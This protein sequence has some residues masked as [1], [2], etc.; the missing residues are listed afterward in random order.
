MM[1]VFMLYAKPCANIQETMVTNNDNKQRIQSKG[2][3][4]HY[5]WMADRK[6]VV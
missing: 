2:V 1:L 5:V 4:D 6:S 3:Q